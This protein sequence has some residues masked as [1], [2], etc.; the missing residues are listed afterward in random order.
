MRITA[1]FCYM[2]HFLKKALVEMKHKL[3]HLKFQGHKHLYRE[4]KQIINLIYQCNSDFHTVLFTSVSFMLI[5]LF[6]DMYW[7]FFKNTTIIF[8]VYHIIMIVI[9]CMRFATLCILSSSVKEGV[10]GVKHEAQMLLTE[11]EDCKQLNYIINISDQ[12]IGFTFL[13]SISVDKC[14]ILSTIGTFLTY[15]ILIATFSNKTNNKT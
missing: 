8:N 3:Y 10:S 9:A 15:G 12:S 2:C 1:Y 14:L 7:I 5:S 11:S 4:Y 13:T 6:G